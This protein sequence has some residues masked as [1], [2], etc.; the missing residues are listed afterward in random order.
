MSRHEEVNGP[1]VYGIVMD[2]DTDSTN[3]T[4]GRLLTLLEA[5]ITNEVQL[6]A[7]KDT[8]TSI[9]WDGH[10]RGIAALRAELYACKQR[11]T[12]IFSAETEAR[13]KAEEDAERGILEQNL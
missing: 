7:L 13:I 5:S 11:G 1:S 6:K 12:P 8:V 9:I 10:N 2:I 3:H 4:I